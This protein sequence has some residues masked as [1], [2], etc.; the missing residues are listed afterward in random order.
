[1]SR[2]NMR[3]SL[4]IGIV[5]FLL[6]FCGSGVVAIGDK[7][8]PKDDSVASANVSR[9]IDEL[10]LAVLKKKGI[11]PSEKCSDEVFIRRVFL[12]V[13]GTIP[14]P[15]Q[16]RG[17]LANKDPLKRARLI[18][19]LLERDE[20]A[21][22]WGLKWGD[23]LRIK[24]EFP[25]NLWPN[26]VQA[27]D[28]WVRESLRQNKHYD[29]FVREL[30]TASGSNF[31]DPPA[32]FYRAFQG[33]TPRQIADNVALL[34]MGVRLDKAGL[35]EDQ[36]LGLSA[37]FAKVGYKGTDE[38]KE[39]IVFFNPAGQLTNA[40]T[41]G[42]PVIPQTPDGRV[43]TLA[44]DQDPRVA[45][46]EWLTAPDNPWFARCIVNRVWYW[47]LGR[48][49]VHEPDDM[50]ASNPPWSPELLAYLEKELVTH[51][52][53]LK[54]I[55][56][57]I[58]NSDTYQRSSV[59]TDGNIGDRDGFSRYRIRRLDAEPLLD[60]INQI[61]GGGE[62]YT[63]NIPE[64]FTFL[65]DDQRAITLSDGS[66]ES[67]FLELFGRPARNT[68]YESE[69]S[70][71]PSVFQVQHLLNSSHVQKKIEK[72]G[73]LRQLVNQKK[74]VVAVPVKAAAGATNAISTPSRLGGDASPSSKA[75]TGVDV[76]K[77]IEATPV[78]E[79]AALIEELYLRILSRFPT[80]QEIQVAN[81]YLKS[82]KRPLT[83]SVCDLVWALINTAEFSLKH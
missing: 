48:G 63:S 27:Y 64:P 52:F 70:S 22:Y 36:I 25:S 69:R 76:S 46:A 32:N 34:F 42:K 19:T 6:L 74:P 16:V 41:G 20:F 31:R 47:L 77:P 12:D 56:R 24:A 28:R 4:R 10:A 83:D 37:F 79:N 68:S 11:T 80:P 44:A 75:G 35:T 29:Q 73:V 23:L 38:W 55:Y 71:V 40:A 67:P 45:F 13:I 54:H 50:R 78:V 5:C 43:F 39:E 17:F 15:Q 2:H 81:E 49:L 62:K 14:P 66:I 30:L 60:A 59:P 58:L 8:F 82:S 1:M 65:P 7:E 53:D 18:D 51:H 21:E 33:R 57:V 9:R 72:S 61:T 26:A 3:F